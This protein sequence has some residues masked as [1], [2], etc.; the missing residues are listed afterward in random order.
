MP[1]LLY[2]KGAENGHK[3]HDQRKEKNQLITSC[4]IKDQ[5][6]QISPEAAR[7][8]VNRNDK[9]CKNT[10]MGHT[11]QPSHKSRGKGTRNEG[12]ETE[13]KGK[14]IERKGA[15]VFQNQKKQ[16]ESYDES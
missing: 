1:F 15:L 3:S 4:F 6:P 11:I 8:M 13:G 16:E 5:A 7:K 10:N 14:N 12:C 9:T 2:E